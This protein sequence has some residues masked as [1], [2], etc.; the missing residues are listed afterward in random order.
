MNVSE[1]LSVRRAVRAFRK[2]PVSVEVLRELA[3]AAARAPSGGNV[4]PWHIDVLTGTALTELK[5]VLAAQIEAGVT[6]MA[7]YD[8]Y[9]PELWSPYNDRRVAV[10]EV[11]YATM[12]IARGD[13][14]ARRRWFARNFQA[15]DAPAV[16]FCSVH[17]KMGAPQWA[18][19]G[20]YL[21]SLM[22]LAVEKSLAT[23][24]QESWAMYPETVGSF[25]RLPEAHMLFCGVAIGYEDDTAPVN[26]T[27]SDR[28]PPR[29]WLTIRST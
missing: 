12:G 4:Q 11:M 5:G 24:P 2:D 29:E 25:L 20:M 14:E 21:Q 3:V 13:R 6:E 18:D 10:G 9:P 26:E 7:Q 8:I 28:A 15:F 17:R 16:Y 27:R 22:L 23:C 19:L 1:A